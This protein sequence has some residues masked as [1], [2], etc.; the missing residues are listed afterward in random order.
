[1]YRQT[2]RQTGTQIDKH[3]QTDRHTDNQID[4][5]KDR[6]LDRFTRE[7]QINRWIDR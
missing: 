6:W 7:R 2:D 5:H 4:R 3:I 1:M